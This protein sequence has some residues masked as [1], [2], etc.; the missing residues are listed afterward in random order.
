MPGAGGLRGGA[1]GV[2]A[3][4]QG[5]GLHGERPGDTAEGAPVFATW[6]RV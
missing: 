2:C 4:G 6:I 3:M 1:R 5:R